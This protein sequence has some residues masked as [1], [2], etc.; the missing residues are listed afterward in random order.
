MQLF[1]FAPLPVGVLLWNDPEPCVTAITKLT[2]SYGRAGFVIQEAQ[3]PL[4]RAI[5]SL[6]GTP[7]ELHHPD[8]F[9]PR[10]ARCD[11]L[12]SGSAYAAAPLS[13]IGAR[14]RVGAFQKRF[15]ALAGEA[16]TAIPLSSSYLRQRHRIE[17]E[18]V[19]VG[20]LSSAHPER[21]QFRGL[22][23]ETDASLLARVA[24]PRDLDFGFYNAAPEDQQIELLTPGTAISLEGLAPGGMPASG[25][26]PHFWP[27]MLALSNDG[28]LFEIPLVCDT[29]WIDTDRS[30]CELTFR[31]TF[32]MPRDGRRR[33]P[34]MPL[35]LAVLLR[36]ATK[37]HPPLLLAD[38]P[39][40]KK[41]RALFPSDVAIAVEAIEEIEAVEEIEAEVT[42][43]DDAA[44]RPRREPELAAPRTAES[45]RMSPPASGVGAAPVIVA[46]HE[47]QAAVDFDAFTS[48]PTVDA[49]PSPSAEPEPASRPALGRLGAMQLKHDR[50]TEMPALPRD[51]RAPS[52]APEP[53]RRRP[54]TLTMT[55]P[56]KRSST[57]PF[58]DRPAQLDAFLAMSAPAPR[59]TEGPPAPASAASPGEE[60]RPR[61]RPQTL[62][63]TPGAA[64]RAVL[65]FL[66][67]GGERT[68]A[69]S[70]PPSAAPAAP[71]A[72]PAAPL[73]APAA[74]VG[75][76]PHAA[77]P[78]MA[79]GAAPVVP[80]A[81]LPTAAPSF[82]L[83][84]ATPVEPP[85]RTI[86]ETLLSSPG[87]ARVEPALEIKAP[88][89]APPIDI[90]TYAAVKVEIWG[91]R[92]PAAAVLA[93][94]G[95]DDVAWYENERR[96]A[97]ALA[98]EA[99]EGE[100]TLAK[101]LQRALRTAR[102]ARPTEG[103]RPLRAFEDV[104][105]KLL[106]TLDHAED[107]S[108]AI[109]AKGVTSAEWR[110]IHRRF[111]ARAEA[112]AK[113]REA[114]A[115]K[116]AQARKAAGDDGEPKAEHRRW[117]QKEPAPK[118]VK[119]VVVRKP[120]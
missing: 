35:G 87:G 67:T 2:L 90:E 115:K 30:L 51:P 65:P 5:P 58:A 93:R 63:L 120:D 27:Q 72:A 106:A 112:D 20:A 64:A 117:V 1:A 82:A 79:L 110:A 62:E 41:G 68:P 107:P 38:L 75:P 57:L 36:D 12:L 74:H 101:D 83:V 56:P 31:G 53:A 81:P 69:P 95:I 44:S 22:A 42:H 9:V 86:G 85:R 28:K 32:Y 116:L 88:P 13:A 71:L 114:L 94:R 26:L 97:E 10:K 16:T 60:P 111:V 52:E 78:L 70:A 54:V 113:A 66:S 18:P 99:R 7:E 25:A 40:A 4:C 19:T 118:G 47:T 98:K 43:D 45:A 39:A 11:V 91:D 76:A 119:R 37:R 73:A 102:D 46:R 29:L 105:V 84:A 59:A 103:E 49:T 34:A 61:R 109:A 50:P 100:S 14:I 24:L 17:S 104:Y 96:L 108:A 92:E 21:A 48:E 77:A 89:R 23:I 3:E 6:F 8:D 33:E 15:F 80:V 55:A